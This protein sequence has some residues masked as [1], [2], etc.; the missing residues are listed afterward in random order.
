MSGGKEY[1]VTRPLLRH[2]DPP[3]APLPDYRDD[4]REFRFKFKKW[5]LDE[6]GK[7]PILDVRVNVDWLTLETRIFAHFFP[8]LYNGILYDVFTH[9]VAPCF[10]LPCGG[11]RSS[12]EQP[13]SRKLV[14][15]CQTEKEHVAYADDHTCSSKPSIYGTIYA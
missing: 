15:A 8:H 11:Q 14:V 9:G 4:Y 12:S 13:G 2:T 3:H 10:N 5:Q 7:S 1:G 6:E